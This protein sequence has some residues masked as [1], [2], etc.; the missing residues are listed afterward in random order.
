[1]LW[2]FRRF[3][4]NLNS[5]SLVKLA[6]IASHNITGETDNLYTGARSANLAFISFAKVYK[7]VKNQS[8]TYNLSINTYLLIG[9]I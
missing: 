9:S 5:R 3:W 4:L 2:G 8:V 1:M 6:A 7:I